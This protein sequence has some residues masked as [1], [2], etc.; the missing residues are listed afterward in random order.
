MKTN[1]SGIDQSVYLLAEGTLAKNSKNHIPL[2]PI[3]TPEELKSALAKKL[4]AEYDG[5]DARL[6]HQAVNE[7]HALASLT[8]VPVL[9]LPALAEEKVQELAA[10]CARQRSLLEIDAH[11]LAA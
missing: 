4:S 8:V 1:E 10:W 3:T 11:A 9:L 5:V 7:A 6:V 2:F